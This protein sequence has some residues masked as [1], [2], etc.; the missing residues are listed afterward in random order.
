[1]E[2]KSPSLEKRIREVLGDKPN[3]KGW[4]D[5]TLSAKWRKILLIIGGFMIIVSLPMTVLKLLGWR[6]GAG[7]VGTVV[8]LLGAFLYS[9]N[10]IVGLISMI[11]FLLGLLSIGYIWIW[12]LTHWWGVIF[13][14][15]F[16][17][18]VFA[19][20]KKHKT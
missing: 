12:P 4:I 17:L 6:T 2:E 10:A 7:I 19:S 20:K 15:G 16:W 3:I 11:I 8:G 13:L 14:S 9:K 5:R 1:M 18:L